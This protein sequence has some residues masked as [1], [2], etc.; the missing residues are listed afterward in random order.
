MTSI[1]FLV[2]MV[3][4]VTSFP[5]NSD[6]E[7]DEKSNVVTRTEGQHFLITLPGCNDREARGLFEGIGIVP[8]PNKENNNNADGNTDTGNKKVTIPEP[9]PGR[10]RYIEGKVI[11]SGALHY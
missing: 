2:L 11:V 10:D 8:L 3:A 5:A 7:E 1:Y 4:V 9:E 6:V